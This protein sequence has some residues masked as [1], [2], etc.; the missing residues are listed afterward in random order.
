MLLSDSMLWIGLKTTEVIFLLLFTTLEVDK[1]AMKARKDPN[2]KE[3]LP[4]LFWNFLLVVYP[5]SSWVERE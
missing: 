5:S 4:C 1:D 2:K 3:F